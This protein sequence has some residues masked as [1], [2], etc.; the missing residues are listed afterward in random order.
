MSGILKEFDAREP[1]LLRQKQF[2]IYL[3]ELDR[4]RNTDYT[5][6]YPQIQDELKDL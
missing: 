2:K 6:I 4:R 3:R 1:D 5:R